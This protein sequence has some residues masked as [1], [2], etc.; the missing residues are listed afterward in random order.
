MLA[1][2]A[3]AGGQVRI[4]MEDA[5]WLGRGQL[6]PSNAAMV[7]KARRILDDLGFDLSTA[8]QARAQLGLTR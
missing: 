1:A 8:A 7:V 4:G 2:S 6:A 3:I 5:V